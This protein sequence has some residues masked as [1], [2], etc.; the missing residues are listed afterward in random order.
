MAQVTVA[1]PIRPNKSHQR[2]GPKRV[3]RMEYETAPKQPSA[4]SGEVLAPTGRWN[5]TALKRLHKLAPA[6][7]ELTWTAGPLGRS[8]SIDG[9]V[10]GRLNHHRAGG[11]WTV[12]IEGFERWHEPTRVITH[13]HYTP[14]WAV[15]TLKEAK[16]SFQDV[17]RS[18][19]PIPEESGIHT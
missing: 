15:Q 5:E 19:P 2:P 17:L 13:W 6:K 9:V 10:I 8:V 18:A 4:R 14:V 3:E 11:V 7:P 1:P 16:R 12:K